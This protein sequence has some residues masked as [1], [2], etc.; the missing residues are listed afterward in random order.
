MLNRIVI[1]PPFSGEKH[2]AVYEITRCDANHK[3]QSQQ[4]LRNDEK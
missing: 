1:D 2:N 3:T 4:Y